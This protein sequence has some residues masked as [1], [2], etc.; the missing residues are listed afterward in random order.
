MNKPKMAGFSKF[1]LLFA[2][3][4]LRWS[5]IKELTKFGYFKNL[6][7]SQKKVAVAEENGCRNDKVLGKINWPGK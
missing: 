4:N 2:I 7:K 3:K 1:N 6:E 5:I